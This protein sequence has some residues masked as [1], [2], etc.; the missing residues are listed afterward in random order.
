MGDVFTLNRIEKNS[1]NGAVEYIPSRP[2]KYYKTKA[3]A[4]R[5]AKKRGFGLV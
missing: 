5:E 2:V 3:G 1:Y 4:I